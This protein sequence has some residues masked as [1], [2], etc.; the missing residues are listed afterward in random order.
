M[1]VSAT[2]RRARIGAAIAIVL[3]SFL[4]GSVAA[5]AET[6][7]SEHHRFKLTVVAGGLEHPWS[8]AFL[9]DGR[10]LVT[11]KGGQLRIV[12]GDGQVSPPVSGVPKTR[13]HGQGGLMDV[14]L[15]PDFSSNALIYLSYAGISGRLAGTDVARARLTETGLED[16]EVIFSAAP[17]FKGGRHFGS[18]LL[19]LPD[20]SLLVT[21]GD[22]GNRPNGQ[23]LGVHP[24]SII[25]INE[26]GTVPA[27]NP[28][29]SL[30]G[31][32]PEIYTYG[33]RNV[34]GIARDPESGRVWAHEHGPQGGCE[35][36]LIKSGAN[37]GWADIT[38]GR[39]Y[40]TGT[41]IGEGEHRQGVNDPA[42]QWTPSIAPSGMAFYSGTKFPQ[43]RGNLFVGSLKFAMLSRMTLDGK[44]IIA[45]E[46]LLENR[47]G[48]I[49]DVRQGPDGFIYLLTDA[50]NGKLV[51]L[52]P[53][54]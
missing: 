48:R 30:E 36:N 17:K 7:S 53:A 26:D 38:F 23:N 39:N 5:P 46:R 33:N 35:I 37:Y 11:E 32:K 6:E 25:R 15:H 45:E 18:R 44:N 42:W 1:V 10:M 3:F 12:A 9:P 43:W 41:R 21:L 4:S 16:L 29:M 28:L 51:R 31:V 20:G 52:E 49:R 22:R 40:V 19:F 27:D 34:Q 24:G 47:L 50:S 8:L 13:E 14:V 54:D 2:A